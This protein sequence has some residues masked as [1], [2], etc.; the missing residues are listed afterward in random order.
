MHQIY[1]LNKILNMKGKAINATMQGSFSIQKPFL[2]IA[3][4][5]CYCC[6]SQGTPF[7]TPRH[8]TFEFLERSGALLTPSRVAQIAQIRNTVESLESSFVN[9][10]LK[11]ESKLGEMVTLRQ[12]FQDKCFSLAQS[13]KNRHQ[14]FSIKM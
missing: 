2:F 3:C 1:S 6:H 14:F 11:T 5:C 4:H 7:T 12:T 8:I 9:L 13:Q 10:K